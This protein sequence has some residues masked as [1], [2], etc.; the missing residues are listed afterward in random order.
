MEDE[1]RKHPR[2]DLEYTIQIISQNGDMVVTALTSNI[3]DGGTRMPMPSECLPDDGKEV[4]VN[5][6]VRRNKTGD[7][8]MYTGLG[9]VLRHTGE[10]EDGE[11]EVV[12][13]FHAP[14]DLNLIDEAE[15]S[16]Q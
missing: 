8:E 3:S 7:V 10:N 6:T 15:A 11:S 14:M 9:E 16:E 5:L 12:L 4:Q 1:R 2:F 13:K